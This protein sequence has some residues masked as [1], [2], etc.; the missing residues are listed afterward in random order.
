MFKGTDRDAYKRAGKGRTAESRS[1]LYQKYK[2]QNNRRR[3]ISDIKQSL[4]GG[5]S[6]SNTVP[7][8]RQPIKRGVQSPKVKYYAKNTILD[9]IREY[10]SS[11]IVSN[12]SNSIAT[13][14]VRKG[15][16][17]WD[18]N[19]K[20]IVRSTIALAISEVTKK[21]LEKPLEVVDNVEL[22]I[23]V[24]QIIYKVIVWL[25]KNTGLWET[26]DHS[27]SVVKDTDKKY[28]EYA[29]KYPKLVREERET[30]NKSDDLH[31]DR[32][33]TTLFMLMSVDGK[34]STGSTDEMDFDMDLP[35][36]D[37]VKEGLH[38]YYDIEKTTD[39]WAF[40]TGKVFAKIGANDK[41]IPTKTT[42]SFV[43]LDN[44]HLTKDGIKYLCAR[45]KTFVLI[46]T[47]KEHPAFD[48]KADNLRIIYQEMLNLKQV[49]LILKNQYGCERLTLQSGGTVNALFLREKLIDYVDI[50]VA[51]VLIG[52]S[53]T[54]TLI[55]GVSLAVKDDLQKVGVLQLSECIRLAN[56]Y[57]RLKYRVYK[58]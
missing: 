10:R 39:L 33:M 44:Q 23:K 40:N 20:D 8:T 7:K 36:V 45:S 53:G 1:R 24:G 42:V 31:L 41:P 17:R 38:Q 29:K 49:L 57:L 15:G 37:W 54:P 32:P 30:C 16:A 13:F 51:P 48:V 26:N 9:D 3:V 21:V 18:N 28:L 58:E 4:L 52:G 14:I 34:I 27:V 19:T 47:N 6:Y 35:M 2:K 5:K 12:I 25:N 50:V 56:S 11:K 46:T 22:F 55:D 43:V